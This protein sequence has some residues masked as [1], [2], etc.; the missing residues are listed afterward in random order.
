MVYNINV[1]YINCQRKSIYISE[2]KIRRKE[3]NVKPKAITFDCYGTLIDWEGEIQKF[4]KR[5]LPVTV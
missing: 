3:I 1:V 5:F 4:S 2:L